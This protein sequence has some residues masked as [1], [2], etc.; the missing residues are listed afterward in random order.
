[1]TVIDHPERV[2]ACAR[3]ELAARLVPV[4]QQFACLVRDEGPAG[5]RTFLASL[6]AYQKDAL[7]VVQA[8]MIPLDRPAAELLSWVTWDEYGR[9]LPG[10]AAQD[11]APP[12]IAAPASEQA[13]PPV[14]NPCGTL[15]AYRRHQRRGELI[16]DDCQEAARTCWRERAAARRA[17]EKPSEPRPQAAPLEPVTGELAERHRADLERALKDHGKERHRAA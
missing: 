8:G 5:I 10:P 1:V 4:A 11:P 15:A 7:L 13:G 3:G 6:T 2:K 9:P 17:A 12:R 14:Q 16:D